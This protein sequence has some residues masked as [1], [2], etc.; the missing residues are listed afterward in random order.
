M[1]KHH[2]NI[3]SL[4]ICPSSAELLTG[5]GMEATFGDSTDN[6]NMKLSDAA[7]LGIAIFNV[8]K[9]TLKSVS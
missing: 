7:W 1:C 4:K 5:V 9:K 2:S 6:P 8:K 3:Y